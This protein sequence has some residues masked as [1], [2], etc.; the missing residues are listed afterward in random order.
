MSKSKISNQ[1]IKEHGVINAIFPT[2]KIQCDETG[3]RVSRPAA[4]TLCDVTFKWE[5][6]SE[7]KAHVIHHHPQKFKELLDDKDLKQEIELAKTPKMMSNFLKKASS[8]SIN[9]STL[10]PPTKEQR[11][12]YLVE[13]AY[14]GVYVS[15]KNKNLL[16]KAEADYA[17]KGIE[18]PPIDVRTLSKLINKAAYIFKDP[19]FLTHFG[20]IAM[21]R[22]FKGLFE[23]RETMYD[24]FGVV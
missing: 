22:I 5:K 9:K 6:F 1:D 3:K 12:K 18:M 7:R 17:R 4:C 19:R 16:H 11:Q 23:N 13:R 20:C 2:Q 14:D 21:A 15:L 24:V 8:S 10:K